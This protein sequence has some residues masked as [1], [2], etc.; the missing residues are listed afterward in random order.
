MED[1]A[2]C[3]TVRK[4]E[5]EKNKLEKI[6]TSLSESVSWIEDDDVGVKSV[7]LSTRR[8]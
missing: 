8:K 2:P 6:R 1:G 4:W 7:I 5:N 3:P